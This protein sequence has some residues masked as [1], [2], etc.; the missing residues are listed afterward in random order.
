MVFHHENFSV[1]QNIP[2]HTHTHVYTHSRCAKNV[3]NFCESLESFLNLDTIEDR[4]AVKLRKSKIS[5]IFLLRRPHVWTVDGW[6]SFS[7]RKNTFLWAAAAQIPWVSHL[8]KMKALSRHPSCRDN[9]D[10]RSFCS[11]KQSSAAAKLSGPFLSWLESSTCLVE[12]KKFKV[13][14]F[15]SQKCHS[16]AP[17][18]TPLT[19]NLKS[20]LGKWKFY[21]ERCN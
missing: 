10:D 2:P 9:D 18:P 13:C 1:Y 14:P 3:G 8:H 19:L 5:H 20:L 21:A 7:A 4:A 12:R 15:P 6:F 16:F 17:T 11:R